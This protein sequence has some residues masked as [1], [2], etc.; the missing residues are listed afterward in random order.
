MLT[1]SYPDLSEPG[2]P[3]TIE[4]DLRDGLVYNLGYVAEGLVRI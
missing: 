1:R 3:G 4:S 2:A